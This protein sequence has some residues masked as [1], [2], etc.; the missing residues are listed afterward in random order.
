MIWEFLASL[1]AVL[2]LPLVPAF[3]EYAIAGSISDSTAAITVAMYAASIGASSRW[4]LNRA[5]F[6]AMSL[7][8]AAF[9]GLATAG[10]SP[11]FVEVADLA[12]VCVLLVMAFH[13]AE[14]YTIH[15]TEKV[16][17]RN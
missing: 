7:V 8:M 17:F 11:R 2:A 5:I 16:P 3:L 13:G 9:F 1:V 6:W 4:S 12:Y 15:V 10:A 14:R